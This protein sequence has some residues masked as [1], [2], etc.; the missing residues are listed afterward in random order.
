V[1]T[2]SLKTKL[3]IG[4]CLVVAGI[5][6]TLGLFSLS[7]FKQQIRENVA[8]QQFALISSIAAH[9]DDN[10]ALAHGELIQIAKSLPPNALRDAGRAQR[11]L[12]AQSEHK[13]TF[14]NNI[15]LL[16]RSGALIAEIPFASGRTGKNFAFSDQFKKT[17]ATAKPTISA[18]F[19]SSKQ[20]HRPVVA[21][22][23]PVINAAGE[24]VG[25]LSASIDLTNNNFLGKLAHVTIGRNGYLC[26]FDTDRTMII[27]PDPK[28]ILTKDVPVG[29]NKGFDQA[30]AGFE[31]TKE[32][33]T[34]KGLPILA[35]YKHLT[36]TN[37]ILAANFP[38]AEAYAALDRT[39]RYLLTA[40]LVAIALSVGVVW[41]Y[42]R[43]LTAPLQRFTGHI[44]SFND[45]RG[46]EQFFATDSGDEIGMLAKTFNGM[47][48]ELNHEREALLAAKLFLNSTIDGL[49]THICVL[50]KQGIIVITNRAWNTF[51]AENNAAEGTCGIGADYL[52]ACRARSEDER[53]DIEEIAASIRG[54]LDGTLPEF[55]KEYPC[56]SPDTE[57][58]FICRVNQFSVSGDT[59]AVISHENITVRKQAEDALREQENLLRAII[60]TMPAS[61]SRI[62]HDLHYILVNRR[63]GELF[64]TT[65]DRLLGRHVR[66]VIGEDAWEIACPNIEQ[67]LAGKSV[68]FVHP[69]PTG[70]GGKLWLQASLVPFTD[71]AGNSSG[72]I[73]HIT[74]ITAIREAADKLC[75]AKEKAESATNAKSQFLANMSHEIRTP[76][77]GVIGMTDLLL[78]TKL[79]QT[80]RE[81][82]DLI[83]LSGNNMLQLINNILDLSK[84]EALMI[85]L[86]HRPFDLWEEMSKTIDLLAI[87]A[88][89]KKLELSWCIEPDVPLLFKGDAGRLRQI[90]TNLTGNAI[91]FTQRGSVAVDIKLEHDYEQNTLLRFTVIDTGIGIHADKLESIFES[92]SQADESTTRKYGG[93]GLGLAISKQ[94]VELMGGGI[95]VESIEGI[96]SK[97]W[98]TVMLKK[99]SGDA[100][101]DWTPPVS[102]RRQLPSDATA[103]RNC[104]ILLAEDDPINQAVARGF[105]TQLGYAADIVGNGREALQLL[106][107]YD[108]HMVLM[109]CQM[110]EMGGM[111]A[112]AVI[113]DPG[114]HVLNHSVPIIALTAYALKGDRERCLAT[115]MDDYLT[116][117]LDLVSLGAV[118]EKWLTEPAISGPIDSSGP[119]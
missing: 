17:I 78:D 36:T 6:A 112:T 83:R 33:V 42:I 7:V 64:G 62:G 41:F 99:Q 31:G 66:E 34:S 27:N 12:E 89:A 102:S 47:A 74:D 55:V 15:V 44:R 116:K 69:L 95:G 65:I 49:S 107:E 92:F 79:D 84:V 60:D 59:Y 23:A 75:L 97:F 63:Y 68:T 40:M 38:Q 85:N 93:S 103:R 98:F 8:A 96:G 115:G 77:N 50:D 76:M 28:L 54:V 105:L 94:L 81:F 82:A 108:Y 19:F 21:L 57:R 32:T 20:N 22:T 101:L 53:A 39:R 73:A 58:W 25:I 3:T 111:E 70:D 56:H 52:G 61:V 71:T 72:Y 104:R 9:I 43:H 29:A 80:Q 110:P 18:P 113:R 35:S 10:L 16:S 30:V 4:I 45:K 87:Q 2:L 118:L 14:D 109:D 51:A 117:P 48:K 1:L 26:L 46:A 90:L 100:S 119:R 24:V 91:K 13:T 37:W 106:A 86:E 5:T 88:H 114:S 67:V 11:F